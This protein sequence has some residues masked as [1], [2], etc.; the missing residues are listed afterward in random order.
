MVSPLR[1]SRA[2]LEFRVSQL[3]SSSPAYKFDDFPED[4][5]VWE[6]VAYG[7]V[8]STPVAWMAELLLAD[9]RWRFADGAQPLPNM[10]LLRRALGDVAGL[11]IGSRWR[12]GEPVPDR[13]GPQIAIIEVDNISGRPTHKL[14]DADPTGDKTDRHPY[15]VIGLAEAPVWQ[16]KSGPTDRYYVPAMELIRYV[17]GSTASFLK[18]TVEGGY[19]IAPT[20]RRQI[21]DVT[22]SGRIQHDP[23]TVHIAAYRP[24]SRHEAE[25]AARIV[26]NTQ[27]QAAFRRVF[28][29]VQSATANK[30]RIYPETI[31]PYD[32]PT[33]W[34]V[35][36]RWTRVKPGEWRKLITRI[37]AIEAPLDVS[38]IV[39][40][41]TG[42]EE[43]QDQETRRPV[44]RQRGSRGSE[45]LRIL[46]DQPSASNLAEAPLVSQ[47][48]HYDP[49]FVLDH[50]VIKDGEQNNVVVIDGD[51]Y[52]VTA[53]S[54]TWSYGTKQKVVPINWMSHSNKADD[55]A[56][57]PSEWLM[58]TRAAVEKAAER[59][60][61]A[62]TVLS[63]PEGPGADPKDGLHRYP[64]HDEATPLPWSQVNDGC[65]RRCLVIEIT[66]P[67][68]HVYVFDAER[69]DD[70]TDGDDRRAL[71]LVLAPAGWRLSYEDIQSLLAVNAAAAGVWKQ[72][73]VPPSYRVETRPRNESWRRNIH[74]YARHI[75]SRIRMLQRTRDRLASPS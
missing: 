63:P 73:Y 12:N 64:K 15:P 58:A 35:E 59:D 33:K 57:P 11:P 6:V 38:R 50:I 41:L 25:I 56:R 39:V 16:I 75:G 69:R 71:G 4:G 70:S 29:S 37:H 45:P 3:L 20:F 14:G 7:A 66:L 65:Q 49:G 32:Q 51:T 30:S 19:Q 47:H 2:H 53:G 8:E 36:W 27:M 52:E 68:G 13:R 28:A 55:P 48:T 46:P 61:W 18:L 5:A 1:H 67:E 26:T 72:A 43:R 31:Y 44:S 21:F 40:E 17:F 42:G 22:R 34:H 62:C 10:R 54:S 24:L 60:G 23:T 9:W 74:A